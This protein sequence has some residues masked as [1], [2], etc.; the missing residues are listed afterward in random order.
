MNLPDIASGIATHVAAV[1][2][3]AGVTVIALTA[4]F[5][6]TQAARRALRKDDPLDIYQHHR[7]DF[8]RGVL[9]GL[10]FLVGADIVHTVAVE[11]SSSS[12][13]ALGLVVLIRAFLVFSMEI[14]ITGRLPWKRADP[15]EKARPG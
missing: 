8:S 3:L 11:L 5:A 15:G 6:V 10:D 1:L 12:I 4:I 13:S 2:E 9:I 14:E 7:L